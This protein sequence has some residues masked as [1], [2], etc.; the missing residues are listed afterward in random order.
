[1]L[2]L[3]SYLGSGGV[4]MSDRFKELQSH[5]KF[6]NQDIAD[7]LDLSLSAVQKYRAGALPV[8]LPVILAMRFLILDRAIQSAK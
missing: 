6:S 3:R 1:V 4:A 7:A 5:L 2:Y 8:P